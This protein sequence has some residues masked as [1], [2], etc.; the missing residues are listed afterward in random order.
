MTSQFDS[1]S[2]L[3][4]YFF[5]RLTVEHFIKLSEFLN[6]FKLSDLQFISKHPTS[7]QRTLINRSTNRYFPFSLGFF[8]VTELI[9]SS[10]VIQVD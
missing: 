8:P 7:R 1:S 3:F 6:T 5:D 4:F 9:N 10:V 2:V